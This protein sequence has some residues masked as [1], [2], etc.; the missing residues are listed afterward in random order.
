MLNTTTLLVVR[1]K[2]IAQ[3]QE[4]TNRCIFGVKPCKTIVKKGKIEYNYDTDLFY[5]NV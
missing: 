3:R 5:R 4:V 1:N 2:T